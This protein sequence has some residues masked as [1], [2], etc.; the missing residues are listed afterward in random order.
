MDLELWATSSQ[1]VGN[2]LSQLGGVLSSWPAHMMPESEQPAAHPCSQEI[3]SSAFSTVGYT[4]VGALVRHCGTGLDMVEHHDHSYAE[5]DASLCAHLIADWF[6]L[7]VWMQAWSEFHPDACMCA[8]SSH[9]DPLA[10]SVDLSAL[11]G[12][13]I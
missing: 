7:A 11:L 8:V 6:K 9:S 2:T 10:G 12:N 5:S 3:T 13:H 4:N 1:A